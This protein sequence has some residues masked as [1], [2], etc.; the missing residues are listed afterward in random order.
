MIVP[1]RSCSGAGG[2]ELAG[3]A[4]QVIP[5]SRVMCLSITTEPSASLQKS[6]KCVPGMT[7]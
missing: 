4:S 3:S 2:T 1:S 6:P 5:P 7:N